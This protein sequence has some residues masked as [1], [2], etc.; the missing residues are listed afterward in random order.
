MASEFKFVDTSLEGFELKRK[1]PPQRACDACRRKKK[2]CPHAA[3][4]SESGQPL[5]AA[6]TSRAV[7][8]DTPQHSATAQSSSTANVEQQGTVTTH[9]LVGEQHPTAIRDSQSNIEAHLQRIESRESGSR[10]IGDMNPEGILLAATTPQTQRGGPLDD[11]GFW[12]SQKYNQS[13]A[14]LTQ[15]KIKTSSNNLFYGF[16]PAIQQVFLPILQADCLVT[17]PPANYCQ[18]LCST[19]FQKFHP[20]LPMI[21]RKS[22]EV[23]PE[24][25][26][27]RILLTQAMCLAARFDPVSSPHLFIS[28]DSELL[29]RRE[30]GERISA[31]MRVTIEIGIVTDKTILMQALAVMSLFTEGR[32]DN[33]TSS[34]MIGRA[35]QHVYS[36]GLHMQDNEEDPKQGYSE[37]LFCCVWAIDRLHAAFQGKPVLIHERDIGRTMSKCFDAQ[38]PVFRLL[39][40]V[41]G[42]LDCVIDSYRPG[43][44]SQTLTDGLCSFEELVVKCGVA[45][46]HTYQLGK[47][48]LLIRRI[49]AS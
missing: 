31:A 19:Y 30:F 21:D 47:S 22:Y 9:D 43:N 5:S 46:A 49:N 36:L 33:E 27:S 23:L 6:P 28:D 1:Q 37:T 32:D 41:V 35:I 2:R 45:H 14:S 13:N 29:N 17:L 44:A 8:L 20:I 15:N 26:P 10:F 7:S 3:G 48:S 34:I 11:V 18:A 40:Y 12:L 25:T 38:K 16:T 42:L 4:L 39:L 24:N